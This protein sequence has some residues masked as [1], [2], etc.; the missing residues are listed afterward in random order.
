MSDLVHL[1][2]LLCL[3]SFLKTYRHLLTTPKTWFKSKIANFIF[4]YERST[5]TKPTL[6][7]DAFIDPPGQETQTR[8]PRASCGPP[9]AFLRPVNISKSKIFD[10]INVIL[11]TFLVNCGPQKLFSSKLWPAEPSFFGMFPSNKFEF[12][13][14]ALGSDFCN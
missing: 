7:F 4:I 1:L 2:I 6:F 9:D 8:G 3:T 13:T 12:V 14:P 10:L 5:R 11:R